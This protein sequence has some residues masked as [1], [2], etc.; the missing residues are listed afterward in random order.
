MKTA[1]TMNIKQI[2]P[3]GFGVIILI[4][5]LSSLITLNSTSTLKESSDWVAHT[6][7]VQSMLKGLEKSLVDA[8]T[9]QRGFLLTGQDEFLAPYNQTEQN[10]D[11]DFYRLSDEISDNPEQLER[12]AK[13]EE[14]AQE[15][16]AELQ[17]TIN[18]KKAGQ[19]ETVLNI[20]LSSQGKQIMDNI[21]IKLAE[22]ITV[23][24]V[25]L[26]QRQERN[27]LD[28]QL[29]NIVS[30]IGLITIFLVG[31]LVL[32]LINKLAIQPI[33]TVANTIAISAHEIA[34]AIEQQERTASG[35]AASVNTTTTTMDELEA[36]S[37]QSAEQADAA[38]DQA[39]LALQAAENGNHTV[40]QTLEGMDQVTQSVKEIADK[41]TR[42]SERTN[43]IGN[44]SLIVSNL[45]SQTNML[46]LNAAVEAVRAG[47][48][49]RGFS[50]VALEIQKLADK[51]KKS[52]E[53]INTLVDEIQNSIR[54]IVMAADEG[55]KIVNW[56]M[57]MTKNTTQAFVGIT[58]TINTVVMYNQQISLNVQQEVIAIQ[59]VV[60]AMES[61]N[62]GAKE[63][64]LG[65]RQTRI[66]TENLKQVAEQL[67]MIV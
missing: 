40:A 25:L 48:Q 61:I 8:E 1:K 60:E 35:Q 31:L 3:L 20:V 65:I 2:L 39:Q 44:I 17:Q 57:S 63:T 43:Q 10:L 34:T 53:E 38:S 29:V 36:S 5:S 4:V 33:N 51:S 42:L 6:Y 49:G 28:Y 13:L 24:S 52:T 14:L 67:K 66:G 41:I 18:L 22:M 19:D 27:K 56:S 46:A 26:R 21:R 16:L 37:R 50:I 55:K 15:K 64:A 54:S 45:A 59:Q 9:G 7:Q 62:Q 30:W 47:E 58:D 11:D 12:L 32:F 23:E